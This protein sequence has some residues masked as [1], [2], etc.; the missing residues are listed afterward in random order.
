MELDPSADVSKVR[1]LIAGALKLKVK[2]GDTDSPLLTDALFSVSKLQ[3]EEAAKLTVAELNE[4][5]K[6]YK[7]DFLAALSSFTSVDQKLFGRFYASD[8][9]LTIDAAAQVAHALGT[10]PMPEG[11][12]YFTGRDELGGINKRDEEGSAGNGA[13]HVGV[14]E[15]SSG[16][17]YF[18]SSVDVDSLLE[19]LSGDADLTVNAMVEYIDAFV[20][21]VPRGSQNSCAADTRATTVLVELFD[22]ASGSSFAGAFERPAHT[23]DEAS[24]RLVS[25]ASRVHKGYGTTPHSA[26]LFTLSDAVSAPEWVTAVSEHRE[27]MEGVR[28]ALSDRLGAA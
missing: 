8:S 22:D 1:D 13:G 6:T 2:K 3:V 25:Y 20:N 24:S 23:A 26:W 7:N 16:P 11:Q 9:S 28:K 21:S 14:K 27:I 15:F 4:R 10:C 5:S 19:G 12:D 18:H 17:L